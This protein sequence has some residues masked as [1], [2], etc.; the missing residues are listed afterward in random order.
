MSALDEFRATLAMD[1]P[2]AGAPPALRALW[3]AG[4]G[5][6]EAAHEEV[7]AHEGEQPCD[8]VHAWLHRQ[9]GDL[10]NARYWY[11]RAGRQMPAVSLED[12]WAALA[13]E[14]LAGHAVR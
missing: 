2:Q 13:T 11:R 1:A 6:W 10:G 9:E 3:W 12:E 8:M 5:A 4:R 14:L 7:Q